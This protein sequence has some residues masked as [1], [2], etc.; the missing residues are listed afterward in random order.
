MFQSEKN[1]SLDRECALLCEDFQIRIANSGNTI[2]NIEDWLLNTCTKP[3]EG[4]D[5]ML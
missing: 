1:L 5:F 4:I 3:D 2:K